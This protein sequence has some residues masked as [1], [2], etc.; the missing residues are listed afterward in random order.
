MNAGETERMS[1]V[2]LRFADPRLHDTQGVID[3]NA[4][5]FAIAVWNA[6]LLPKHE[7]T[8]ALKSVVDILPADDQAARRELVAIF[9]L[10]ARKRKYFASNTRVMLDYQLTEGGDMLNLDV[11]STLPWD[12]TPEP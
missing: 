7:H 9:M 2:V 8:E 4:I 5:R 11:V 12:D 3:K 1:D 6:S 10:L